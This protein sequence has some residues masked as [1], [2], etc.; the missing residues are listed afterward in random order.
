M[1]RRRDY[2]AEYQRRIVRNLAK[3]LSRAA[4]RGHAKAGEAP[5]ILRQMAISPDH[6]LHIGFERVK[7]G[8]S[9]TKTAAA[10]RMSRERLR[11]YVGENADF[12]RQGRQWRIVQDRRLYQ[13]PLYTNGQVRKPVLS[14]EAASEVGRFMRAVGQFLSTNKAE[15]LEPFVGEGVVNAQS[16]Y[17]PFETD[18]NTLYALDARGELTFHLIYQIQL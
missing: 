11:R 10:L 8:E 15:F 14:V 5:R 13:L 4:A 6:P 3:G 17:L 18:P 12:Q 16:Q 1:A 9:L 2:R 7:A